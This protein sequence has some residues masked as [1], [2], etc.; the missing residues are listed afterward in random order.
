LLAP[1]V[2]A[3]DVL[4][5]DFSA[6][7]QPERWTVVSNQ[8]LYTW[9]DSGGDIL[10][11]KPV[12]GSGGLDLIA[13][14]LER[15]AIGDFDLRVDFSE[16]LIDHQSGAVGN[17]VQLNVW[18]GGQ[19]LAVVRSDEVGAGD[20]AHLFANPPNGWFGTVVSTTATAETLRLVRVGAVVT[21]WFGGTMLH[22]GSFNGEPVTGITLSLQNNQTFDAISVR[23]DDFSLTAGQILERRIFSDGFESGDTSAW[24]S[25]I[26]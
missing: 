7:V 5:D 18:F 20:N 3:A 13:L 17:Q 2:A 22:Q 25:S 8:P 24:S 10:F 1:H 23:F 4:T 19:A 21:A 16:A 9:D 6:G 15:I 14:S 11:A 12:G 26:P